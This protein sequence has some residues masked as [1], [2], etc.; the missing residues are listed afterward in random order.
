MIGSGWEAGGPQGIKGIEEEGDAG[1]VAETQ[2]EL[3]LTY[4]TVRG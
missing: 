2:S 4:N 1:A 3:G